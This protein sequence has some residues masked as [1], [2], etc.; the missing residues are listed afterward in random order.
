MSKILAIFLAV[1]LIAPSCF[2]RPLM[3]NLVKGKKAPFAGT[4]LNPEA[5]A[6]TIA[7]KK[8]QEEKCKVKTSAEVAK[9]KILSDAKIEKVVLRLNS[10]YLV[11]VSHS[12]LDKSHIASLEKELKKRKEETTFSRTTWLGMGAA[13]G[14]ALVLG[15]LYVSNVASK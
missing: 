7:S 2:A 8:A 9:A 10:K 1:L 5:V 3:A 6:V 12:K 15:V 13:G 11:L 14:I 4:L